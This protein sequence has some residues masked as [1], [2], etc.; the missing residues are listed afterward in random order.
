[1]TS[2]LWDR[3]LNHD[4]LAELG[5]AERRLE[6]RE[7]AIEAGCADVAAAVREVADALDGA[8][9]L[10]DL[11]ADPHVTDV[12]VNGPA[13]VWVERSGRL[14]RT[15]VTFGSSEELE[16]LIERLFGRAGARADAAMPLADARLADGS[17]IHV[18]MTPVAPHGP[19]LSIR[20]HGFARLDLDA[21]LARGAMT[22]EQ[23]GQLRSSVRDGASMVIAGPTGSGKTTL[24]GA[25]ISVV[26]AHERVVTIEE[27]AELS[28]NH[29]HRVGLI[30]RPGNVEGRG[31]V[32]L[33][34][35][36]RA[37][38]RMRPDRIVVGEVRGSEAAGA[39]TAMA[40][41]HR[42]S[43]LT[44]HAGSPSGA[45]D[46]L[47]ALCAREGTPESVVRR[48]VTSAVNVVVQLERVAQIRKVAEIVTLG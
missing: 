41:G 12:L 16:L 6:L 21:L 10:T 14:V 25:L 39:L 4:R 46:R 23:A 30:A 24:L 8:G 13:E 34:S 22:E 9:P 48:E 28:P 11:L 38:L 44:I 37:A 5:A 15:D 20:R 36:V 2:S 47:V 40:T 33:D 32:D 27:T 43:M 26:P 3:V 18:A 19:L 45:I 7:L 17:R 29:P 35:L 1:M 42:G 31:A